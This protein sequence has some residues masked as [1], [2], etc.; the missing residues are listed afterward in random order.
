MMWSD[1]GGALERVQIS[2]LP[3]VLKI[4]FFFCRESSLV[5]TFCESCVDLAVADSGG[6]RGVQIYPPFEGLPL[7][8]LSK[9]AQT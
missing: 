5:Q 3:E 2:I 6:V 8:V 7:H 9:S 1:W 4:E